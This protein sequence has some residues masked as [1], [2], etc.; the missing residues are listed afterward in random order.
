[1]VGRG[2]WENGQILINTIRKVFGDRL[3]EENNLTLLRLEAQVAIATQQES[4]VVIG[5]L[6]KI[7]ALEPEDGRTL[8][9]LAKF[10]SSEQNIEESR[11]YYEQAVEIEKYKYEALIEY[12]Q[13]LVGNR[14]YCDAVPLLTDALDIEYSAS[15]EEFLDQVDRACRRQRI[16]AR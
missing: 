16:G 9:L 11:K 2:F 4:D 7:L 13:M 1:M 14:L 15:V 10:H 3:E 5:F 8:L 12:S 6:E